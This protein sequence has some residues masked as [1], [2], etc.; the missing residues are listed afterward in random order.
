[1]SRLVITKFHIF[2]TSHRRRI[3][4][5]LEHQTPLKAESREN[6]SIHFWNEN[7]KMVH[8]QAHADI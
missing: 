3:E 5:S 8:T 4:M 7:E 6:R 1:M 2:A